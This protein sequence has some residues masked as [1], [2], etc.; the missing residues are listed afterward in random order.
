MIRYQ[1]EAV[2]FQDGPPPSSAL[3]GAAG[4]CS[5][6]AE[7]QEV[8]DGMVNSLL[9]E[10]QRERLTALEP[11]NDENIRVES[12]PLRHQLH[13]TYSN[14]GGLLGGGTAGQGG[15]GFPCGLS[16]G[17]WGH[18]PRYRR[19]ISQSRHSSYQET[20]R[21]ERAKAE[22]LAATLTAAD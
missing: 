2:D 22:A 16:P 5:P 4:S 18:V 12:K 3:W 1:G 10:A 17:T 9:S 15:R 7:P 6:G 19:E 14:S 21:K 11:A 8:A 13:R 20:Q